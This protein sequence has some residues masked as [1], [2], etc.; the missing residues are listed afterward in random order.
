MHDVPNPATTYGRQ[1]VQAEELLG[2]I[3]N[4]AIVRL[5]K[6][7]HAAMPLVLEWSAALRR[8]EVIRPYSDMVF[9]PLPLDF[10]AGALQ[11]IASRATRSIIHLSATTDVS[12]APSPAHWPPPNVSPAWCTRAP[13]PLRRRLSPVGDAAED[14]LL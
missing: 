8:R 6:V 10:V 11:K 3:G 1:K 14:F 5:T 2:Q 4:A 9:N 13:R 7:V 12:Y